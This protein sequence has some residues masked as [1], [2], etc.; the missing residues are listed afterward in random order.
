E[1]QKAMNDADLWKDADKARKLAQEL[2]SLKAVVVPY[3]SIEKGFLDLAELRDMAAEAKDERTM[4]EIAADME[5]AEKELK[6][7]ELTTL[8]SEKHD[9][10]DA[11]VSFHAGAG[12]TDA[13]DWADM[14]MRMYARWAER[15]G[16][17]IEML[18]RM[19]NEE[20][21]IRSATV[22]VMG[23]YAYGRMKSEVGVHRLIRMSPFDADARRHT[24]F[25]SVD[26]IPVLEDADE[27][28]EIPEK[29]LQIDTCRSGGAGGQNVNK[30]ETVVRIV[31]LPTGIVV[32]CQVER[33]QHRNRQ[34]AMEILKAKLI[35]MKNMQ[36]EKEMAALYGEKGEIAWANQIRSYFL[37]PYTLV[38]DHRTGVKIG[39]AHAVLDGDI[40]G[41]IEA[42]LRRKKVEVAK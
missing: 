9:A 15:K 20:A 42:F 28:M 37:Q 38:N 23:P 19:E 18:D 41:L 35:H 33:S 27:D 12:G 31:H 6:Q 13:C 22:K 36:R 16:Y 14:L 32:R 34:I 25:A 8:L 11:Y 10:G 26:V 4:A 39:D 17:K 1:I 21:G 24:S 5:K 7:F 3:R 2:K 29:D 30:V 40:D